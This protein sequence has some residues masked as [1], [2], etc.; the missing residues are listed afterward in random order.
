MEELLWVQSDPLEVSQENN[1][2]LLGCFYGKTKETE[3]WE[4][5]NLLDE[6]RSR[7][8]PVKSVVST[9]RVRFSQLKFTYRFETKRRQFWQDL[10]VSSRGQM[11]RIAPE[12]IL[13]S[14]NFDH[15]NDSASTGKSHQPC[16]HS[17]FI[18]SSFEISPPVLKQKLYYQVT[19]TLLK[20][21]KRFWYE[22]EN[23]IVFRF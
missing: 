19:A 22:K 16:E 8:K 9:L 10:V 5:K 3:N 11:T 2:T 1:C 4:S 17:T 12:S 7:N 15:T 14:A 23:F 20:D 13:S 18:K 6:D 21:R